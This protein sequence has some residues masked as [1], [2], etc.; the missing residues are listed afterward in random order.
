[1]KK[2]I[3]VCAVLLFVAPAFAADW[4]FYGSERFQ[5]WWVEKYRGNTPKDGDTTW[6]MQ[7]NSRIGAKVKADKVTGQFELALRSNPNGDVGANDN[8]RTRV[9]FG[10][11]NF[12]DKAFLKIGKDLSIL[13]FTEVSNQVYGVDNDLTGLVPAGRR[14]AAITLGLGGLQLSLVQP[15]TSDPPPGTGTN[16]VQNDVKIPKIEARYDLPFDMFTFMFG[17]GWQYLELGTTGQKENIN[18]YILQAGLKANIGAAYVKG[19]GFYGQNLSNAA[20]SYGGLGQTDAY[21]SASYKTNGDVED[22]TSFGGGGEAGLNFTDTIAFAA[23]GGW[24]QDKNDAAATETESWY[25]VYVNMTYKFAPG[26]KITPEVGYIS[27]E[28]SVTAN[29]TQGH[30]VYAGLQ[31]RIDF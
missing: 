5:T 21:G 1:M 26:C 10:Q 16:S 15:N 13:D 8:V 6:E 19:A 24:R 31:W 14:T 23:G 20:W 27:R 18:S 11:W 30:D 2:L 25:N 22:A 17:G 12:A 3:A 9:M 4:A 28:D 29:T 7:G